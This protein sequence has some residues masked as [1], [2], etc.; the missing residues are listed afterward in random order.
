MFG[1]KLGTYLG[2]NSLVGQLAAGTVM[3]AI[4]KEVGKAL[5]M[6]GTFTLETSIQNAFGTL[7]GGSG[8]GSL[9][10]GAIASIS[11]LLMSELADS[12]NLSGFEGGLFQT[13]GTTITSQL[14]TN[15]Y[16]MM[17]GATYGD[18]I[19][20]TMFTGFDPASIASQ[21]GP[22]VALQLGTAIGGYLGSTLSAHIM[23]PHY[24]E[25]A[26]GQQVGSSVGGAVGALA[27]MGIPV[28]GPILGSFLGS[29]LGGVAGSLAG[30]LFGNDPGAAGRLVFNTDHRFWWDPTSFHG[31][32]GGD[33][34]T[35]AHM[36]IYTANTVNAL[37]DFAGVQMDATPVT[38]AHH[39]LP[40]SGL[41]LRY[42]QDTRD[43]WIN[44]QTGS[45]VSLVQNVDDESDIAPMVDQGIMALTDRVTISGGDPLVRLAWVNSQATS[46][47]GFAFDLQVAKDY[48]FYL[49]DRAMIDAVMAAEPQ[50]AFTAG[51][52]LTLLKAHE[53]GLDAQPASED[54]RAGNDNLSGS[55]AAD[56]LVGGAGNDTLNGG[57]GND[58]LRGD[59]GDDTCAG[60][61][62]TTS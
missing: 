52:V 23:V 9:P 21:L 3:G 54:F 58:R 60:L 36:A 18:G 49:D 31:W 40:M 10:S 16:G 34:E 32:N 48:R 26:I 5:F 6:G 29:F 47:S 13:V 25:G 11:S 37:A 2:G 28:V 8:V 12:L 53:L 51:W 42:G 61:R 20:Y 30:D 17:T 45:F 1:S 38:T 39:V 33:G 19:A 41:Q 27:L 50:S 7:A 35:F 15:A 57:A 46:P 62:G 56:F 44:D 4:G 22:S 43:F 14:I 24:Q 55:A 59:A